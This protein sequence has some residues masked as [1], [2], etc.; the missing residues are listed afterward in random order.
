MRKLLVFTTCLLVCFAL[1]AQTTVTFK[2]GPNGGEDA[3]IF[4]TNGCSPSQYPGPPE[5]LNFGSTSELIYADWTYN[6]QGCPEGTHRS[7]IRFNGLSSIPTGATILNA[8][9]KLYGIPTAVPIDGNSNYPGSPF[10]LTNEGLVQRVTSAWDENTV[11]WATQPSTT[12]ANQVAVPVSTAQWNWDVSLNVTDIVQDIY[13][14]G[15][16]N[17]ILLRLQDEGYYRS[18]LFASSDHNDSI[19]W[20]ELKVTY[21]VCNAE[22]T[23]SSSSANPYLYTLSANINSAASGYTWLVN[24]AAVGTGQ[25]IQHLFN[26]PGTYEVCLIV[27]GKTG[28]CRTCLLLCIPKNRVLDSLQI[29]QAEINGQKPIQADFLPQADSNILSIASVSPN[30]TENGWKIQLEAIA[31]AA[32]VTL[33]DLQGRVITTYIKDLNFGTNTLYQSA[34]QLD[35]GIYILEVKNDQI[36]Q[37]QKLIK[38]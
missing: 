4:T 20:P 38:R 28:T 14:S 6:S 25:S 12:T 24:G 8:T 3:S 27:K 2:P 10:Q 36:T 17:G 11:T 31:G 9:L 15:V 1:N 21:T 18:V 23:Y 7:L 16:N 30:P 35:T 34:E 22:F 32:E 5:Q 19:L 37:T 13:S 33:Y 26:G 29:G